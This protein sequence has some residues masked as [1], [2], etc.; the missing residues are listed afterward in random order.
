MA[1]WRRIAAHIR[2]HPFGAAPTTLS[3]VLDYVDDSVGAFVLRDCLGRR[4]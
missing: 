4:D 3:D 1:D 2:Q